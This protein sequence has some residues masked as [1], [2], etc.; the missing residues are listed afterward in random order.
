MILSFEQIK[1]LNSLANQT[2]KQIPIN[3]PMPKNY[4]ILKVQPI[5]MVIIHLHYVI[6]KQHLRYGS[7]PV[8]VWHYQL[9]NPCLG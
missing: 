6:L 3:H 5:P 9:K 7:M 1:W 8:E 2:T 4:A